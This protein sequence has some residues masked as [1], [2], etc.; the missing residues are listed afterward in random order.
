M[1]DENGSSRT[2]KGKEMKLSSREKEILQLVS[3]G[4]SYKQVAYSLG[5][6]I[7]MIKVYVRN[8]KDKLGAISCSHAVAIF[9]T[10]PRDSIP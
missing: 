9:V 4:K 7:P 5:I 6:S 2:R 3:E 10:I 8:A 1:E